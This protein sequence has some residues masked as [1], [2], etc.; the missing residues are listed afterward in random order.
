MEEDVKIYNLGDIK[1]K[2]DSNLAK[3]Y[4]LFKIYTDVDKLKAL[5]AAYINTKKS[6]Y[7]KKVT[8]NTADWFY[9]NKGIYSKDN[10]KK[11]QLFEIMYQPSDRYENAI[12]N[13]FIFR[14]PSRNEV[15]C[16]EFE[17]KKVFMYTPFEIFK[18]GSKYRV[19]GVLPITEDIYNLTKIQYRDF[20]AVTTDN[21]SKYKRFFTVA[22]TPYCIIYESRLED[23]RRLQALDM[24]EYKN[25]LNSYEKETK[26]VKTLR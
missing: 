26:L 15:K 25:L 9:Y 21:I 22:N 4:E 19:L 8:S 20:D 24:E 1:G 3:R 5:R 17:G 2:Y 10:V 6:P 11:G 7:L 12:V 16:V 23:L 13:N 18:N 14:G